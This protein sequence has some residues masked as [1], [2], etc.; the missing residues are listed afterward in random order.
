MENVDFKEL[1]EKLS[2]ILDYSDSWSG[3]PIDICDELFYKYK[4][5]YSGILYHGLCDI[6]HEEN[7]ITQLLNN[8]NNWVSCSSEFM[9]SFDFATPIN[10]NI[11]GYV[12]KIE[13]NEVDVLD[14]SSLICD[15]VHQLPDHPMSYAIY[16]F[17][18][19]HEYLVDYLDIKNS[20][21]SIEVIEF[22]DKLHDV[23]FKKYFNI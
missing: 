7:N 6:N 19:E 16:D 9:V 23:K 2:M 22:N 12:L 8:Y 4:T 14:V 20:I 10:Q 1:A 11:N 17:A 13:L 21:T 18:S 15:C 5:K 3:R